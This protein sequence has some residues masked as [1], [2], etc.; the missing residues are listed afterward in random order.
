MQHPYK[1][2][3]EVAHA[4]GEALG[5]WAYECGAKADAC[6]VEESATFAGFC[7]DVGATAFLTAEQPGIYRVMHKAMYDTLDRCQRVYG[8]RNNPTQ[9]T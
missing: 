4:I 8:P 5:Q 1:M 2:S 9:P 6:V 7:E 3:A